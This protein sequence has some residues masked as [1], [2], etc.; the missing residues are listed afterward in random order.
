MLD[1]S[2]ERFSCVEVL[3]NVFQRRA[4]CSRAGSRLQQL[5]G[6]GDRNSDL[7]KGRELP[8]EENQVRGPDPEKSGQL[9]VDPAPAVFGR[10][11]GNH[12]KATIEQVAMH[13]R[14]GAA[15]RDLL[16]EGPAWGVRPIRELADGS[17]LL[18]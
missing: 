16:F 9:T 7:D 14:G 5:D 13:G 18:R 15:G 1:G 2:R 8:R 17:P 3:A 10:P 4:E 11:D 6:V 12:A